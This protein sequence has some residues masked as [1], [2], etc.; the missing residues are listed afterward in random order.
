MNEGRLQARYRAALEAAGLT[1][2]LVKAAAALFVKVRRAEFRA[3]RKTA[4]GVAIN[5][6]GSRIG[7]GHAFA[8]LSDQAIDEMN[9]MREAGV[10]LAEI[11]RRFRV[12]KGCVWKVTEGLRRGQWAAKWIFEGGR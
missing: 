5:D 6:T 3:S 8:F 1:H 10:S 9:D 4:R 2:D 11:G 12:S 7:E